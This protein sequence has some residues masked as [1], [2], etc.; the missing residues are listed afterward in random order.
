MFRYLRGQKKFSDFNLD[1]QGVKYLEYT[2]RIS[3]GSGMRMIEGIYVLVP[4]S[5]VTS[6]YA[7]SLASLSLM[8]FL[9]RK[10]F[11][12]TVN[13]HVPLPL[14]ALK[15]KFRRADLYLNNFY[16]NKDGNSEVE[17]IN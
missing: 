16:R 11:N 6:N 2:D 1:I 13:F 12:D 5:L 9:G 17:I 7:L 10:V 3:N 15:E 8:G 4:L 14:I